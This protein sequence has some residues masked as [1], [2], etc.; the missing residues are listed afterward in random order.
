MAAPPAQ[1]GSYQL[2]AQFSG[3][4]NACT[5][6][7]FLLPP[8]YSY[9]K[10][11]SF[12]LYNLFTGT[13][14]PPGTS[15]ADFSITL[16]QSGGGAPNQNNVT[17]TITLAGNNMW[18]CA[19]SARSTLM[20]NFTKLLLWIETNLELTGNLV[21]G[22]TSIIG[23]Q[24]AANLPAPPVETLFY[25]YGLVTG[26][27]SGTTPS[28]NIVPGMQIRIDTESS[29][30]ISPGSAFNGYI[31]SGSFTYNIAS[32]PPSSGSRR[33]IAFDPFLGMIST[34]KVNNPSP[35]VAGGAIDL[36]PVGGAQSY[37]KLFYPGTMAPPASPGQSGI[38]N[39]VALVGAPTLNAL[40]TALTNYPNPCSSGTT[41]A[42]FLGRAIV[43]PSIPIYISVAG[44]FAVEWVPVGTTFRNVVERYVSIQPST[45]PGTLRRA[46][47]NVK[48]NVLSTTSLVD[49]REYDVPL[50]SGD[51][52][53]PTVSITS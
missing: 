42:Y 23:Q 53:T 8:S 19:P 37:W 27:V 16:A 46:P 11:S 41:C 26:F 34:P 12:T 52:V 24:I 3:M 18:N 39:N 51:V 7:V 29:Q 1:T 49:P 28:V 22:A 13:S 31:S 38:S 20:S 9:G 50:I 33:L 32:I 17:V 6:A 44:L 4:D 2:F 15:N 40:N 43:V 30:F 47:G 5:N 36:Q 48:F 14:V 35:V 10:S 25:L 21:P 45:S